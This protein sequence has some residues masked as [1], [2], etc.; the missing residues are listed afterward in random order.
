M[1]VVFTELEDERSGGDELFAA[2]EEDLDETGDRELDFAA[3]FDG[4][5][6]RLGVLTDTDLFSE[7]A[8]RDERE[9]GLFSAWADLSVV[10]TGAD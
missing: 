7:A 10:R 8:S 2:E 1:E 6:S 3:D 9:G 5:L 4:D